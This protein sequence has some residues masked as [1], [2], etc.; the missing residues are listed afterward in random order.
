MLPPSLHKI[1]IILMFDCLRIRKSLDILA[2]ETMLERLHTFQ[3][4]PI[5]N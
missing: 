1:E 4:T 2:T 3:E 5:E